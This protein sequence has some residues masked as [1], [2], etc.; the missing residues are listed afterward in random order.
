MRMRKGTLSL[1]L[2]VVLLGFAL[3]LAGCGAVKFEEPE[4]PAAGGPPAGGPPAGGPPA[5]PAPAETE[6]P[7]RQLANWDEIEN[8]AIYK[9][10][11]VP[12]AVER[13][14]AGKLTMLQADYIFHLQIVEK[15]FP[16]GG[17]P[18]FTDA[19]DNPSQFPVPANWDGLKYMEAA[20]VTAPAASAAPAA[21]AGGGDEAPAGPP[22]GVDMS[23]G[24]RPSWTYPKD[25][26]RYAPKPE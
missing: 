3:V 13:I 21:P 4:A 8:G 6:A 7:G 23:S 17:T 14:E 10:M 12:M 22:A 15:K 11:L 2:L 16:R 9:E 25:D 20:G 5:A 18:S 19:L 24:E 1:L 26:P